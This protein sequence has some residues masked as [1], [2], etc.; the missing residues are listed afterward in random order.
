M[1]AQKNS[2][3]SHSEPKQ[4]LPRMKL[5]LAIL[6][7]RNEIAQ[8]PMQLCEGLCEISTKRAETREQLKQVLEK[9]IETEKRA[10]DELQKALGMQTEERPSLW[11]RMAAR[12]LQYFLTL[13]YMY[14][15]AMLPTIFI[16]TVVT[17][18]RVVFTPQGTPVGAFPPVLSIALAILWLWGKRIQR[19]I[20]AIWAF[21]FI[22]V[23]FTGMVVQWRGLF[24]F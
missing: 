5:E 17:A 1:E 7:D 22:F 16:G 21:S 4:S 11:R 18:W 24:G 14:A 10:G 2:P 12:M 15:F 3:D 20:V 8:E 23:L 6:R 9:A 19:L 13:S